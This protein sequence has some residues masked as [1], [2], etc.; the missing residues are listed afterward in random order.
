LRDAGGDGICCGNGYGV[1]Q[2]LNNNAGVIGE[3]DNFGAEA[4]H[5]WTIGGSSGIDDWQALRNL[6]VYPNPVSDVMHL[7]YYLTRPQDVKVGIMDMS[8]RTVKE[9]A[10]PST[11]AGSQQ[12]SLPVDEFSPGLYL[13]QVRAGDYLQ[14]RKLHITD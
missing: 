3:G 5:A 12:L 6:E 11:Q 2:L 4:I 9:Y 8:G 14:T 10:Y 13:L 7:A 1:Y